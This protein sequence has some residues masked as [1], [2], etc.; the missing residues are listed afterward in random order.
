MPHQAKVLGDLAANNPANR[1]AIAAAG[2]IAG[3]VPLLS[4]TMGGGGVP[5]YTAAEEAALALGNL[6]ANNDENRVV[7][8]QA[9]GVASLIELLGEGTMRAKE[10]AAFA[11]RN[12]TN[13]NDENA[14]EAFRLGYRRTQ[15]D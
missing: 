8:G 7:I 12:L 9:G 2:G 6:A 11:L 5:I 14:K 4:G 1:V 10:E 15:N 13:G 3:L